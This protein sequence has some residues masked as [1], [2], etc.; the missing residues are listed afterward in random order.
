MP[1]NSV[2]D[3]IESSVPQR[4]SISRWVNEPYPAWD[5]ILTAHDVARLIRRSP[6]MIRGLVAIG[7]LPRKQRFRGKDIGWLKADILEWMA[8]SQYRVVAPSDKPNACR[9]RRSDLPGQH[10]L[11][12][13]FASAPVLSGPRTVSSIVGVPR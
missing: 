5:R 9:R 4:V 12:L 3:G 7:Q 10:A 13:K 6:W 11:P 2:R 1:T 8:H